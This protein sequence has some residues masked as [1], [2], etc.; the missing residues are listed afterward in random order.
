MVL[1]VAVV[2][3]LS[4]IQLF[5]TPLTAASQVSLSFTVSWSL[6]KLLSIELVMPSNHLLLYPQPFPASRSFPVSQLFKSGG[7]SIGASASASVFPMNI[8]GGFPLRLTG[9]MS[10][11]SKGLSRVFPSTTIW[12]HRFLDTQSSLWSNSLRGIVC[13]SE[14]VDISLLIALVGHSKDFWPLFQFQVRWDATGV[15]SRG[16]PRSDSGLNNISG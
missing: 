2:Q 6:F 7:Q 9:L 4:C 15:L 8:Q 3:S 11:L 5:A 13:I 1:V 14:V 16:V 10:L 12:K